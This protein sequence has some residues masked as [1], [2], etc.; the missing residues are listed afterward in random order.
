[1]LT[2]ADNELLTRVGPATK[3]GDVMRRYWHPVALSDQLPEPDCAPLR[4]PLLG[5]R[6]VV[7][8]DTNGEVGV[9]EE[10]CMHR[11]ASLAIGRVEEGGIR[12][13]YHGW[14]FD[15][16][17]N[18][19]EVPNHP[20]DCAFRARK[21]Q[22]AFP[23][24]E[25]SGLIWTYIG[26]QEH[27]PPFRE[28]AADAE[29]LH[30]LVI[31]INVKCNWLALWEG[32]LD[33]SHVSVLHTNQARPSWAQSRGITEKATDVDFKAM[34]D[35]APSFEVEDTFF[36]YHYAAIREEAGNPNR[37]VRITPAIMP[38]GRIIAGPLFDFLVFEV[39]DDDYSTSTFITM[40]STNPIDKESTFKLLGLDDERYWS[41]DDPNYKGS[42]DNNF[43]QDRDGMTTNWTG[44]KGIEIE[45]ANIGLSYGPLYDRSKENLVPADV[46][47]VRIR[48]RLKECVRRIDAG[49]DPIGAKEWDLTGVCAPDSSNLGADDDWRNL[50]PAHMKD[51]AEAS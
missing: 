9:L 45:D 44:F 31:R 29:D 41:E 51:V 40:Y 14:K 18:V 20:N 22:P 13:I 3:M 11:G 38:Y 25:K 21:K 32:G 34:D 30:R 28:F 27:Q 7:F 43:F 26:P 23:T 1:M 2:Q 4:V 17:G 15:V 46:A 12:C 33:S 19:L 35:T 36:G 37:N 6:L 5:E 49:K 10:F 8:R 50:A 16:K 48:R 24:V 39:P 47:V 42:W